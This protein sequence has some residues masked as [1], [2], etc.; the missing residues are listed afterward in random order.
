[1]YAEL[2]ADPT[3]ATCGVSRS[4]HP[5]S[6]SKV[7]G[8]RRTYE[9]ITASRREAREYTRR[10]LIA[11]REHTGRTC[12]ATVG[13]ADLAEYA[14]VPV[15][16]LAGVYERR[17]GTVTRETF[18][19]INR[20]TTA[21][22]VAHW[23]AVVGDGPPL[24]PEQLVEVDRT[25]LLMR[26]L[27]GLG[28]GFGEQA[29]RYGIAVDQ[30]HALCMGRRAHIPGLAEVVRAMVA[31]VEGG[32]RRGLSQWGP[33][34]RAALAARAV[35][36]HPLACYDEETGE[37]EG[38]ALSSETFGKFARAGTRGRFLK[39]LSARYPPQVWRGAQMRM[40]VLRMTCQGLSSGEIASKVGTTARTVQRIRAAAGLH[41]RWDGQR[42][43]LLPGSITRAEEIADALAEYDQEHSPDPVITVRRLGVWT[44]WSRA[45]SDQASDQVVADGADPAL[46]A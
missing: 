30:V 25:A 7:H 37:F 43:V 42:C 39:G 27:A 32:W 44:G 15:G 17:R 12:T 41:H 3:C 31:E 6:T 38:G 1:M 26:C 20:I 5:W 22:L 35:G 19:R 11:L 23:R 28:W 4:V 18:D 24:T 21:G 16:E 33:N 10:R 9:E 34:L 46:A 8:F 45:Q 14:G 40:D 29:E 36:W 2:K 13:I